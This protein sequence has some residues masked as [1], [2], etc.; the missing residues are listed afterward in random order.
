MGDGM[1]RKLN[2]NFSTVMKKLLFY[3]TLITPVLGYASDWYFINDR[4]PEGV[5]YFDKE[6]LSI[7]NGEITLW[8]QK[9]KMDNK[10]DDAY[11][12]KQKT[13]IVCKSKTIQRVNLVNYNSKGI[14]TYSSS[15]IG[16][17]RDVVPDSIG[18]F[19]IR[20]VCGKNFPNEKD[21]DSYFPVE[22]PIEATKI[23]EA[24]LSKKS[25]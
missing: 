12:S 22:N 10:N 19:L 25:K 20:I 1:A 17:V 15:N 8:L 7:S 9:V 13:K 14:V 16:R 24:E 3:L 4:N 18:D 21:S 2:L 5:T 11:S 6:S 23:L